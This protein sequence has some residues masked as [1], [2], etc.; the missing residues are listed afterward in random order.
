MVM[1]GTRKG[2]F[3]LLTADRRRWQVQGPFLEGWNVLH[4][5]YDPRDGTLYAAGASNHYGPCVAVSRDL[6][7]SW[8]YSSKG[9][10]YG[11]GGQ[12]TRVWHVEPGRQ[13]GHLYAGVE[14]AGLFE[15]HDGG[16]T[17]AEVAG[18]RRTP[19]RPHWAPGNGGLCLHSVCLDPADPQRMFIG[20][21]AAGTYRTDDAG[22]TWRPLN[23]GIEAEWV[24]AGQEAGHCV[25]RLAYHGGG[26]V[27]LQQ[28]HRGVY[29]SLDLGE[30]WERLDGNG[31]PS[32][33]GFP[34]L[35]HPRDPQTY[36]VV[37]LVGDY[38]RVTRHA[39]AVWRSRDGGRSW[40]ELRRGL[41]EPAHLNVL[42]AGMAHDGADPLGIYVGTTTGQ[43][44]ATADEG[45][46]WTL[47]ADYLPQIL[48]VAAAVL[49]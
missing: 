4:M 42:R 47:A 40:Q 38:N 3:L 30:T 31:L 33:F 36:Y 8:T 2:A 24:P 23:R 16:A 11:D 1:A 45:E 27:L 29:R 22:E 35:V 43:V 28:N 10:Q 25:H 18:L 19:T 15:S 41:P 20:I 34:A 14:E 48:G 32:G 49:P 21:S 26:R 7:A 9:L 39:M 5:A 37:P 13:A 17:F 6:G 44:F 46:T 12:V